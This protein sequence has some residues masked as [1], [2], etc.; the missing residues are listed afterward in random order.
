MDSS[1]AIY[2]RAMGF[3]YDE[4]AYHRAV[5]NGLA[6]GRNRQYNPDAP[7]FLEY[8]GTDSPSALGWYTYNAQS[9]EVKTNSDFDIES[10]DPNKSSLEWLEIVGKRIDELENLWNENNEIVMTPED[11]EL[12]T[13]IASVEQEENDINLE[14]RDEHPKF[15]R[16]VDAWIASDEAYAASVDDEIAQPFAKLDVIERIVIDLYEETT[17]F[18]QELTALEAQGI[19]LSRQIELTDGLDYFYE[20]IEVCQHRKLQTLASIE[21]ASLERL[22]ALAA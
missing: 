3:P 2:R 15:T 20:L 21:R 1:D 12:M 13:I 19:D 16:A 14:L 8:D 5:A 6:V 4:D 22:F 11:I 10:L 9:I 17:T 18:E 7:K